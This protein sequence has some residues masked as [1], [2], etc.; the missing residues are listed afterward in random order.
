MEDAESVKKEEFHEDIRTV[1]YSFPSAS[2]PVSGCSCQS[3]VTKP[4]LIHG[5]KSGPTR[6]SSKGGW[7]EEEDEI[8]SRMVKQFGGK[9]WK[10]IAVFFPGRTDVQCL[11]RWQ[12]VLN[13]E[14]IK[15]AWTKEEDKRI[16]E[17]I[18]NYGTKRWSII[19]RE[20][21]G[22]IGK[23]C[24][25]RWHNHLNP[26]IKKGPWTAEEEIML[27]RAH[28]IY[29][30]KWAEI[31]KLLPGRSDNSI[32]NHWNC[33]VKKKLDSYLS[34]GLLVQE[35]ETYNAL[36]LNGSSLAAAEKGGCFPISNP[37]MVHQNPSPEAVVE[38]PSVFGRSIM[39]EEHHTCNETVETP[40][41]KEISR[42]LD[43]DEHDSGKPLAHRDDTPSS[44]AMLRQK[45]SSTEDF[46]TP[47]D[48]SSRLPK[49]DYS[50]CETVDRPTPMES[51]R[52]WEVE[53][54]GP[55]APLTTEEVSTYSTPQGDLNPSNIQNSC[56]SDRYHQSRASTMPCAS[57]II[58]HR[59]PTAASNKTSRGTS[60]L[61]LPDHKETSCC[62][63]PSVDSDSL[64]R[65]CYPPLQTG[66]ICEYLEEEKDFRLH[67]HLLSSFSSP[68]SP[69][70]P[71]L[72]QGISLNLKSPRFILGNAAKSFKNIPSILAKRRR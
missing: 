37:T 42:H 47:V 65:I 33:S 22:R 14:L 29:G 58:E 71:N 44:S 43:I 39:S 40:G 66:D 21:R 67:E 35:P 19:A 9:N 41:C 61:P 16:I 68:D 46:M 18:N 62:I 72:L 1:E 49:E 63:S 5:R 4:T 24:R 13:P 38:S 11:H 6:R 56:D 69:A 10:K 48:I 23:Q 26:E 20:M 15:G 51:S 59:E 32:K 50:F 30:N 28:Q 57:V 34:S 36:N 64:G 27:I 70:L 55:A 54:P 12:K 17:L 7:T 25:E 45:S 52:S 3:T 8:L 2:S 31:S 60:L 53:M